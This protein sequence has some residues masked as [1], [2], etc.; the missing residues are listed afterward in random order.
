M[1]NVKTK[2][3][4]DQ[5]HNYVKARAKVEGVAFALDP[6]VAAFCA[7]T[8]AGYFGVDHDGEK[9]LRDIHEPYDGFFASHAQRHCPRNQII[10]SAK[11]SSSGG[12]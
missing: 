5:M 10:R 8:G 12:S 4:A 2:S 3:L 7:A 11:A 9:M 6:S 1:N